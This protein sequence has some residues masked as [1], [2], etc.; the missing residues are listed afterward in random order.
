VRRIHRPDEAQLLNENLPA[1]P[2]LQGRDRV[3]LAHRAIAAHSADVLILDDGFQHRRLARDLDLVLLDATNP[4]G[5]G[6]VFPRGLLRERKENL[7]RADVI[8]LTRCDLVDGKERGRLREEVVRLVPGVPVVETIHRPLG[9]VNCEGAGAPVANLLQRRVAA[10]CGIGNPQAFRGTLAGLG[11]MP[12]DFRVFPDHHA[13]TPS[14]IAD[15]HGWAR[16]L[17]TECT[18]VTTQKDLVKLRQSRLGAHELW[19]LR[20][21]LH[22]DAGRDALDQKLRQVVRRTE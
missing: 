13:Y 5:H 4:W 8:I 11:A 12:V 20:I 2:H 1:V 17:G 10:F 3:A 6:H 14:D 22:V 7:R 21:G 16:Q 15:L 18:V 9:L 19:A